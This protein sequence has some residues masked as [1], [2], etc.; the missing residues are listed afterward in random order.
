MTETERQ[1]RS[2]GAAIRP[3]LEREPLGALLLGLSSGA[4][5]AMIAST[6]TTR[7]AESGIDK[8]TVT[9][10]ALTFL[11]YNFKFL[12]APFIDRIRIP[13]LA[14]AVGQ[15]RA[16]LYVIAAC[17]VAAIIWMGQVDPVADIQLMVIAALTVAFFGATFDIIIDAFRI[18]SLKPEQLGAGSGM[19]QYGWRLGSNGAGAIALFVANRAGWDIAY[20]AAA[21][22]AVPAVIAGF[23]L[24]EPVRRT[25]VLAKEGPEPFLKRVRSTFIAPLA[26]FM[27]RPNAILVLLFVLIHKIGDTLANLSLRILLADLGFDKDAIAIYDVMFGLVAFLIGVFVGG[28]VYAK[29]GMMRALMLCLILMGVSNLMFAWLATM[30]PVN[31]ALAAT[32]GFENFASGM[33]GVAVVAYLSWLCDLRFTATQFALLSAMSSILGRFVQ[34]TTAGALIESLGFVNFYLLTTL[35]AVPGVL[36]FWLLM[37]RDPPT[38]E[39][40]AAT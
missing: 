1:G 5:F 16:W 26:D 20:L 17:T 34:G 2:L 25:A 12:W 9:A 10:F 11:L 30:G 13:G 35:L 4:P 32:M 33:G 3:Y 8:K 40:T 39:T 6:L 28:I 24:G 37:R 15:R 29:L 7:L 19:S 18:D 36:L 23:L 31:W 22:F 38:P 21:F 27:T 14:A